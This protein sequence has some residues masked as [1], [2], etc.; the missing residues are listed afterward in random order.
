VNHYRHHLGDYAKDTAHLS[1]L[2]HGVYGQLMRRYYASEQ[3]LPA[4][5]ADVCRWI[6]A[7]SGPERAAVKNVLKDFFELQSDGYHQKRIDA[8]IAE[9]KTRRDTNRAIGKTGGRPKNNPNGFQKIT[10]TVYENNPQETLASSHKPVASKTQ[11][12]ETSSSGVAEP[13]GG[14]LTPLA[15]LAAI[16]VA[17]RVNADGTKAL[18]HLR[19][20]VADGVTDQQLTDAIA[21]ARERK[22]D[23]EV[24][25]IAYVAPI[26]ADVRAGRVAPT[27]SQQD[28]I[29]RTI[30]SLAAKEANAPH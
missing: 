1:L 23:P 8:E 26:L 21:L 4:D 17:R 18:L 14:S 24:I 20:W 19:Q 6:G 25:P 12:I 3:P 2:E 15:A 28:V 13:T 10:E 27:L 29:A 16:C 11:N 5:E 22:P 9:Y 7:R 30:A